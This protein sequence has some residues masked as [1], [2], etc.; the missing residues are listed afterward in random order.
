M[1]P[2]KATGTN[3]ATSTNVIA[4]TALDTCC[5]DL[6]AA[7]IGDS[8][9]SFINRSTFSSTTIASSTTIPTESTM[10]NK[11]KVLMENPSI[12]NPAKVPINEIGTAI[13]GINVARQL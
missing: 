7:L 3:T 4:T 8:F 1:P 2:R 13:I 9:S 10:A 12:H 6:I 11:V 5:I